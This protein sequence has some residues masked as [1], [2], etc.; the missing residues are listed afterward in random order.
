MLNVPADD[1]RAVALVTA[2]R[3]GDVDTLLRH[4]RDD[5]GLAAVRIVDDRG[6]SRTLLHVAADWPGHFPNG[7]A[8]VAA[9]IAAGADVDARVGHPGSHGSPETALHWAASSDDVGVLDALLDGGADI[10]APGAVFT[11]G[12]AMS[13]A[14]VFAQ[15]H[16]ARRLLERGAMTTI[17][18]SAALGLLDRVQR[19]CETT[20]SPGAEEVTNAFWHACGGGQREVAQYLRGRGADMHWIGYDRRTPLDVA[21]ESGAD[22]LV[23]WLVASGAKRADEP[24]P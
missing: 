20:P 18:Q 24:R 15:W 19:S 13:D 17:W 1:P 6:V 16:A 23:E 2:I 8:V 7:P 11:G 14:V 9:L 3:G 21:H 5:P 22:D 12:T 10:E 4:L